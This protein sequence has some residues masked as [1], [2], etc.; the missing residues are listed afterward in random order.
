M[1]SLNIIGIF[2]TV[3]LSEKVKSII[4]T[5]APTLGT[6]LGGPLGGMAGVILSNTLGGKDIEEAILSGNPEVMLKIKEAE[7]NFQLKLKELGIEEERIAAGDRSSARDL[8]KVNSRPP[9]IISYLIMGIYVSILTYL[10]ITRL[11]PEAVTF[12]LGALFREMP[13]IMQFWFGS[14]AGSK[15]KSNALAGFLGGP[16]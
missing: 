2:Q 6:A 16:K 5:I 14:S 3:K 4:A 15:E 10:L 13:T 12:M 11:Y 7:T 8:A 1:L 9:E